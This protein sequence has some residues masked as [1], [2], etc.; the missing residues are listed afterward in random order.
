MSWLQR[1]KPVRYSLA[2]LVFTLTVVLTTLATGRSMDDT[3]SLLF[4]FWLCGLGW[5]M[6]KLRTWLPLLLPS[7]IIGILALAIWLRGPDAHGTID[8]VLNI[9]FDSVLLCF[10]GSGFWLRWTEYQKKKTAR[11][12]D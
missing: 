8:T 10:I 1:I 9:A 12:L 7:T 4:V 2:L 11:T 5:L 3:L 6:I